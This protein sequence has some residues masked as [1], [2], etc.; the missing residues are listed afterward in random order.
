MTAPIKLH[1]GRTVV[2]RELAPTDRSLV[3]QVLEEMSDD[4]LYRRFLR[5]M[6]RITGAVVDALADVDGVNHLA[7]IATN[8]EEPAGMARVVTAAG[9]TELA[10]EIADA[11]TGIGLGRQLTEAVLAMAAA[12][13]LEDVSLYVAPD[14]VAAYRLFA[15]LGA[16]FR[17]EDGV[18][19]GSIPTRP[20]S[21]AA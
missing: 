7:V 16:R 20:A 15:R 6:P 19:T 5:P 8:R 21:R 9:T 3:E 2:I 4:A 12:V 11:Y 17:L 13:G 14:N 10:V 1:D 18:L